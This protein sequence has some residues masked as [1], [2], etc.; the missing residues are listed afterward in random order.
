MD[1]MAPKKA[2]SAILVLYYHSKVEGQSR[3]VALKAT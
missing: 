2:I 1:W 3:L